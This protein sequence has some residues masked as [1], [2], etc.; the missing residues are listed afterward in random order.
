MYSL[1]NAN[2]N[3]S[4]IQTLSPKPRGVQLGG[5]APLSTTALELLECAQGPAGVVGLTNRITRTTAT[6]LVQ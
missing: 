4:A 6:R 1:A 3:A 2:S 5:V